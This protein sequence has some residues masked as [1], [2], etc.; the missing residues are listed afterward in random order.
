MKFTIDTRKIF[1]RSSKVVA[2]QRNVDE[3]K[4]TIDE[5][6]R[7]T[8]YWNPIYGTL[9]IS[10][11][12]SYSS[13]KALN[14]S[15]YYRGV[16]IISNS[17]A[18]LP[19]QTYEIKAAPDNKENWKYKTFNDLY[20]LLNVQPNNNIGSYTFK[21]TIVQQVINQGNSYIRIRRNTDFTVN[22]FEFLNP[23]YINVLIDGV[24]QNNNSPINNGKKEYVDI[25]TGL[26]I[27]EA[28]IIHIMNYSTN[29]IIGMSTIQSG[30]LALGI[31]YNS[32][33]HAS[34]FFE[35]GGNMSMIMKPVAGQSMTKEQADAAKVAMKK[36]TSAADGKT[37]DIIVL[38]N[39]L[40]VVPNG[41]SPKDQQLLESRAFNI[42]S[43]AQIL[44]VPP[45]KLFHTASSY[46]SAEASQID[47]LNSTILSWC[48]KIE[49]EFYRKIYSKIEYPYTELE[50][51]TKKLLRLD[52]AAQAT[53]FSQLYQM[54]A[55]CTNEIR[56]ELNMATPVTGGNKHFI[57]V[58]LQ[59][60]DDLIVNKNNSIDNQLK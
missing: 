37:G 54:G 39:G 11:F 60:I 33:Q 50:F 28:D 46:A 3:L 2:L 27:D 58:N 17:I 16:E 22:S 55:I 36:A 38:Q 57:Q 43:I 47:F 30:A 51:D 8:E 23:E 13:S 14:V 52:A 9:G 7:S 40:D 15:A 29:G 10:N 21:K 49:N 25:R 45:S 5:F 20:Y 56:Q 31:A 32:E 26:P 19:L 6:K 12:N 35:S 4:T 1:N 44:G 24:V 59:P 34:N 42:I 41:I 48:E 53:H 18:V